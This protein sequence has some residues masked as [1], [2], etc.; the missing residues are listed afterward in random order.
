MAVPID[1][2]YRTVLNILNKEQRGFVTENDFNTLAKQAQTE[3]FEKYFYDLNRVELTGR[4]SAND[5]A[6]LMD[7]IEEK[8]GFFN[9]SAQINKFSTDPSGFFRYPMDF[10][11]LNVVSVDGNFA[12]QVSHEKILYIEKAPLTRSTAKSP[13]YTRDRTSGEG[14]QMYPTDTTFIDMVYVRQPNVPNWV[15]GVS[16]GQI[17]AATTNA[18][19]QNFELHSSEEPELVAK[20]LAYSGVLVRDPEAAGAGATAAQSIA[21]TES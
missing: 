3:I 12:D 14:I 1:N 7:N 21:Q 17:V 18:A 6:N 20:I 10:Y 5:Y 8:I 19:Y 4:M 11:R 2:V 13:K 9:T 16:A 15:G